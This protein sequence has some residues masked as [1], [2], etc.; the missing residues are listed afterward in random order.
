MEETIP[1]HTP[2]IQLQQLLKLTGETLTG[3]DAKQAIISGQV[4]V[5]GQACTQRGKK[6]RPGDVVQIGAHRFRVTEGE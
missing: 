2:W 4:M 1:V 6:L 3:G 5:N